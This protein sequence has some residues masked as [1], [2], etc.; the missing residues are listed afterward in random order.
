MQAG[1]GPG[2][3][4]CMALW[5]GLACAPGLTRRFIGL[6]TEHVVE[7]AALVGRELAL[8]AAGVKDDRPLIGGYGAEI[9]ECV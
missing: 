4:R 6:D 9:A 7:H 1:C 5:Q 8:I 2:D 3:R